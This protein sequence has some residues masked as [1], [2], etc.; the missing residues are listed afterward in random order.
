MR[1]AFCLRRKF[2]IFIFYFRYDV[3]YINSALAESEISLEG[4]NDTH[5]TI[6]H[7]R[8]TI[9]KQLQNSS[10]RGFVLDNDLAFSLY[11]YKK[12][13]KDRRYFHQRN[14][15]IHSYNVH[16]LLPSKNHFLYSTLDLK[17]K[18]FVEGGFFVR[19]HDRYMSDWSLRKPE[20]EDNRVVLTMDHLSVGFTIWL[21]MLLIASVAVIV[22][23]VRVHLP[24]Y[25]HGLL[26]QIILRKH[27]RLR[28]NH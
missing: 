12:E 14:F 13:P 25:L 7:S 21:G 4:N 18:Q 23:L 16:I 26:F 5:V 28:H 6:F 22:E 1:D 17:I 3:Q 20:L 2:E 9:M 8:I 11:N 15:N 19:W 24:H 10:F 27:Q